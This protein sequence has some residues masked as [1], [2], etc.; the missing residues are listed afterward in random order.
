M[1]A[2]S[3][4]AALLVI[5]AGAAAC[6][7]GEDDSAEDQSV[8]E[9][10]VAAP[11]AVVTAI[12]DGLT[13]PSNELHDAQMVEV[14]PDDRND[15]GYPQNIVAANITGPAGADPSAVGLW[16]VNTSDAPGP[17]I[18]LNPGAMELTDW[19]AAIE[20]GSPMAENRDI[21]ASLDST[22]AA[23]DCLS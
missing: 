18:G 12:A 21:M 3:K 8:A 14:P 10:C 5:V 22:A 20:E 15:E 7:S 11:D 17:I 4:V 1:T 2:S 16:A 19:G 6:S 13:D 9:D 23:E